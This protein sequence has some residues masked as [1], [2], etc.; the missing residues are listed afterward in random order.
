MA[1]ILRAVLAA[2]VLLFLPFAAVAKDCTRVMNAGGSVVLDFAFC[3]GTAGWSGGFADLPPEGLNDPSYDLVF[4]LAKLPASAGARGQALRLAGT[5]R[6]DDLFMFVTRRIAGLQP[7]TRYAARFRVSFATNA[8]P[9]CIGAGGAP[10]ESVFV[11][12][13]A[14]PRRP[15]TVLRDG[16]LRLDLDIGTQSRGGKD[17]AVLGNVAAPG[18]GCEGDRYAIKTLSGRERTLFPLTDRNGRLW[19]IVGFDSGYEGRSDLFI[20]RI[21]VELAPVRR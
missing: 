21:R 18:L 12:A 15:R 3:G 8:G 20:R 5:N 2:A 10:G 13:G 16:V 14:G 9:G 17:A 11:K 6:S 4:G 19:L 7:S 1:N